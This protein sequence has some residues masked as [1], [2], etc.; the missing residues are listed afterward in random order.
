MTGVSGVEIEWITYFRN[1]VPQSPKICIVLE[2]T[3]GQVHTYH[4]EAGVATYLNSG[5]WH[6]PTYDNMAQSTTTIGGA[7]AAPD[8]D[9]G[10][11][12]EA[13]PTAAVFPPSQMEETPNQDGACTYN[14]TVYPTTTYEA[15]FRTSD[16]TVYILVILALSA[17]SIVLFVVYGVW[18]DRRQRQVMDIAAKSNAIIKSLFPEVVRDRL[19]GE[20]SSHQRME[21]PGRL[22]LK[23]PLGRR[24]SA[25]NHDGEKLNNPKARLTNFLIKSSPNDTDAMG[26]HEDEPIAEM[27]SNTTVVS[28]AWWSN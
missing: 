6:D 4:V 19:F 3:C 12:Q 14:I 23:N 25:T 7:A 27:F 8:D 10:D 18:L 24:N 11:G 22:V 9:G 28:C 21:N 16:T 1:I 20:T 5:D 2:N 15:T 26:Y 13:Y 17:T